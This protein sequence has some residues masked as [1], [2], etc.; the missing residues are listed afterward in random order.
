MVFK[1][2]YPVIHL[3]QNHCLSIPQNDT[4]SAMLHLYVS[5]VAQNV[6]TKH[7]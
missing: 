5:T 6:Q 2:I 7:W 1:I 4:L 3:K